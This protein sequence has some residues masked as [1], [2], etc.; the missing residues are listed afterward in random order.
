MFGDCEGGKLGLGKEDLD[1]SLCDEPIKVNFPR[2]GEDLDDDDVE[3]TPGSQNSDKVSLILIRRYTHRSE[4]SSL[5]RPSVISRGPINAKDFNSWF[6]F[7]LRGR[8]VA[9]EV[10][11]TEI[12]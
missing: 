11:Y 4:D 10:V 1:D 7:D 3:T 5:V 8:L 6:R 9:S 12:G 2:E